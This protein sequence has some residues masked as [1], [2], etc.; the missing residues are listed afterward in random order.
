MPI[1]ATEEQFIAALDQRTKDDLILLRALARKHLG[2]TRFSDPD[3]LLH[4]AIHLNLIGKRRWPLSVVFEAYMAGCMR[5]IAH[6]QRKRAENRLDAGRS[7]FEVMET[8]GHLISQRASSVEDMLMQQESDE[9]VR[10][11]LDRAR[12]TLLNDQNAQLAIDAFS[13]GLDP[14]EAATLFRMEMKAYRAARDRALRAVRRHLG[15]RPS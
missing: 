3:D 12:E 8:S 15:A 6:A 9:T 13:S 10:A 2:G 5:S 7:I 14:T 11:A 4:E 1:H